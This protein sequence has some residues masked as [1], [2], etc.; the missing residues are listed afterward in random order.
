MTDDRKR[1]LFVVIVAVMAAQLV[2][3]L[4]NADAIGRETKR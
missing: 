1:T 3:I 2:E 4:K